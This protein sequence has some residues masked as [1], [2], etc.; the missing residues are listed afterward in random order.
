MNATSL[1][2][3]GAVA[4]AIGLLVIV[5]YLGASDLRVAAALAG[6]VALG[7]WAAV[8]RR[9][10]RAVLAASIWAV[11]LA[12]TKFRIR[13]PDASLR[14]L[15]DAQIVMELAT[16]GA[17]AVAIVVIWVFRFEGRQFWPEGWQRRW[18]AGGEYVLLAYAALALLSTLWSAAPTLTLVRGMQLLI[19][20]ALA[21]T[22]VRLFSPSR[23]WWIVSA[24]VI[25][26]VLIGAALAAAVP[27]VFRAA[28]EGAAFRFTWFAFRPVGAGTLAALAALASMSVLVH[29]PPGPLHTGTR[30]VL[31]LCTVPLTLVLLLTKAR[32]PL[33]AFVAGAGVLLVMRARPSIRARLAVAGAA[34][35]LIVIFAGPAAEGWLAAQ[36]GRD[37]AL[38]TLIFRGQRPE[39]VLRLSGRAELW[40]EIRP[41]VANR[42][43]LGYGYQGSRSLLLDLASWASYAHNAFLQTLLDLGAIGVTALAAVIGAALLALTRQADADRQWLR[44]IAAATAVFLLCNSLVS[45]SFAAAPGPELFLLC[46]CALSGARDDR[47]PRHDRVTA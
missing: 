39:D 28:D 22:A 47:H 31:G 21:M 29:R 40:E 8:A 1:I 2:G 25:V 27:S 43:L 15:L 38:T 7:G 5:G 26:Y 34:A 18:F 23:A 45:E 12:G 44:A 42:V 30:L 37:S 6:V 24:A 10:P 33:L 36:E 19:L 46:L 3:T 14:G 13:E 9:H 11:L 35:A 4:A 17:I 41:L 16:Y 32:G 20:V